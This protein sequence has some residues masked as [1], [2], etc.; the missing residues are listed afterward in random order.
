MK[1]EMPAIQ[2]NIGQVTVA[3]GLLFLSLAGQ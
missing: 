3:I 1:M 2:Y